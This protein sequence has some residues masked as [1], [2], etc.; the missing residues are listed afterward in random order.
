MQGSCTACGAEADTKMFA[1]A[2]PHFKEVSKG[3]LIEIKHIIL[4]LF[5]YVIFIAFQGRAHVH[6]SF[7]GDH[8][9]YS[10]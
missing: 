1:T 2:I 6:I 8:N 5:R 3:E 4:L 9:V 7:A 10:V